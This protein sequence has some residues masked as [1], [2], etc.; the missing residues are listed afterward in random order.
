VLGD[1]IELRALVFKFARPV[2]DLLFD[3]LFFVEQFVKDS[4]L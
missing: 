3:P 2:L 1:L 4:I